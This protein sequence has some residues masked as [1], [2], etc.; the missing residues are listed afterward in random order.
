MSICERASR[1]DAVGDRPREP[2]ADRPDRPGTPS[3]RRTGSGSR[4]SFDSIEWVIASTPV[5][6]VAA[7][8]S[9]TVRAGSRIVQ[10]GSTRRVA[11]IVLASGDLVGDDAERVAFG[12]GPGGRRDG[13]DRAARVEVLTVIAEGEDIATVDGVQRDDL[14]RIDGRSAAHRHDDRAPGSRMPRGRRSR[15]GWRP[16]RGSARPRRTRRP[17]SPPA[18]RTAR[19]RSITPDATTPGI[20]DDEDL[21]P[22][23]AADRGDQLGERLDRARPRTGRG[24]AAGAR[25]CD[26]PATASSADLQHGVRSTCRAGPS[27]S[28]GSRRRGTSARSSR[29]PGS[30]RSRPRRSRARRDR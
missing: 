17:S 24:R 22:A 8:G 13:D 30:R 19:T 9:P 23:G 16:C 28:A 14:G 29:R 25:S 26:P 20:R 2:L 21:S 11:D 15:A 7:G 4:D 10:T 3:P 1:S 27:A 6:A 18:S 12:P 5:A